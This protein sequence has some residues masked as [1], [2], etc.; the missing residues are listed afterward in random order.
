[1]GRKTAVLLVLLPILLTAC[2]RED[3][4]MQEA[5]RFRTELISAGHCEFSC[6]IT[7]NYD[8]LSAEFSA[9]CSCNG[10]TAEV[11]VTA[12][13]T[14]SGIKAT[15]RM[16]G[17]TMDFEDLELVFPT[18]DRDAPSPMLL[19]RLM[20]RAWREDPI[21]AAG[22]EG[23]LL[24]VTTAHGYGSEKLL[25]DTWLRN[26]IPTHCEMS[27]DGVVILNGEIKNY[28]QKK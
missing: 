24:R 9:D 20:D 1:M 19:P 4:A 28:Q 8:K 27:K 25:L 16:D 7:A 6:D 22:I 23:E 13:E 12:P 11:R 3:R 17:A 2:K 14:I 10:D 5:L 26:G 15:V 18:A 21:E